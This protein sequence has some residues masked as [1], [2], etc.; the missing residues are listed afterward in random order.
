MLGSQEFLCTF[1]N[2]KISKVEEESAAVATVVT[3]C[4]SSVAVWEDN[5][6]W[7]SLEFRENTVMPFKMPFFFVFGGENVLVEAMVYK[8]MLAQ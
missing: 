4:S 1:S 5:F 2:S 6:V 3:T 8:T 7:I